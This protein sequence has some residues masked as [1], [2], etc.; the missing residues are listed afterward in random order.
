MELCANR[1]NSF[2]RY[3]KLVPIRPPRVKLGL[4]E[5]GAALSNRRS[6]ARQIWKIGTFDDFESIV[7]KMVDASMNRMR[8]RESR[9]DLWVVEKV[10][11][12]DGIRGRKRSLR[13]RHG[14]HHQPPPFSSITTTTTTTTTTTNIYHYYHHLKAAAAATAAAAVAAVVAATP[15]T[16]PPSTTRG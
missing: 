14:Y 12:R 7:D 13:W 2:G 8:V 1:L 5:L 11:G 6:K 4:A 9:N 15:A 3:R 16:L 10:E